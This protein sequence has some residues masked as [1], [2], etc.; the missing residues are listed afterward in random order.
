MCLMIPELM[1]KMNEI[2]ILGKWKTMWLVRVH[3]FPFDW[4]AYK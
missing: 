2:E 4:E 1:W 3:G